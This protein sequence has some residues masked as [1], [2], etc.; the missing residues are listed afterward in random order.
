MFGLIN[1]R[2]ERDSDY[3][4]SSILPSKDTPLVFKKWKIGEIIDQGKT[5]A[6]VACAADLLLRSA[7][8]IQKSIGWK[9]I[10]EES[11][12]VDNLDDNKSDGTTIRGAMKVLQSHGYLSNYYWAQDLEDV[13][14]Y[15]VE[16]GPVL[17]GT[18]WYSGMT[19][20]DKFGFVSTRGIVEDNHC[21]LIYG[22]N[23][24]EGYFLAANSWGL[25]YGIGG[26]FKIRFEDFN[27][28]LKNGGSVC[29]PKEVDKI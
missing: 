14:K 10:F 22:V 15:L 7:P 17:A 2:D 20:I 29:A 11:K 18:K 21:Y 28:L 19:E 6:C 24:P 5:S 8:K 25:F 13:V 9:K 3:K 16:I 26:C 4:I 27:Y 23:V 1:K 12:L